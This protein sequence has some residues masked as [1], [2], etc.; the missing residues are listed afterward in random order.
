MSGGPAAELHARV[1]GMALAVRSIRPDDV[2]RLRAFFQGLS[3]ETRY[4]RFHAHLSELA[5]SMWRYLTEVD[6]VAHIAL[7]AL[8][9]EGRIGGVARCIRVDDDPGAGE[10]AVVVADEKQGAGI[11]SLLFD[12]LARTAAERGYRELVAFTL[13]GHRAMRRL[14][15][16]HGVVTSRS[17]TQGTGTELR[18]ALV[19][20]A[21]PSLPTAA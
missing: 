2:D 13:P 17:W 1:A 21:R 12:V 16:H 9:A 11:G 10:V 5:P 6:G 4:Q 18:V 3:A 7:I 20:P 15:E 19:P 8:D 14:M